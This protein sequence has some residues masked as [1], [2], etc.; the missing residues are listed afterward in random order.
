VTRRTLVSLIAVVLSIGLVAPGIAQEGD[1]PSFDPV[2]TIAKKGFKKTRRLAKQA[3][4][5]LDAQ[6]VVSAQAS[7]LVTTTAPIGNYEALGGPSVTVAVPDSGL[8]EVWAQ[9]EIRDDD[10]GA[11]ALF[12]DNVVQNVSDAGFCGDAGVL[13][14]FEGGGAGDFVNFST[15]PTPSVTVGCANVGA[16]GPLLIQTTPGTHTFELRYSEC[17]CG[18]SAEFRHRVL[19]VAAR[20]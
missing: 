15:P 2:A 13:I 10:G 18:G 20:P 17:V 16:P 6:E 5:R 14:E 3:K 7:N 12:V 9:A 8:V 19:R 4:Q 1:G 11:V